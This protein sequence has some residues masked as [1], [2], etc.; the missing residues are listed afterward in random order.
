MKVKLLLAALLTCIASAAMA[1]PAPS[2]KSNRPDP[3]SF[4]VL[5]EP[6]LI[7]PMTEITR[8]YALHRNV[9]MLT[10]FDD[11]VEQEMKLLDGEQG[12]VLITSYPAV[13][14][15]LRQ[16]GL[17]DV[18]SQASVAADTLVLAATSKEGRRNRGDLL[19]ALTTQPLLLANSRR[20]IE[21]LYGHTI[22]RQLYDGESLL[23]EPKE[24][25]LRNMLY[26]AVSKNDGIGILL[27]SEAKKLE[28]VDLIIPL[29]DAK[30]PPVVYQAFAVAGENMPVAR[31]FIEFL[32]SSEAQRIFMRHGFSQP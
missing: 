21:G 19:T 17:I 26:D 16:R 4:T 7:L 22:A 15:D 27:Q 25:T 14:T 6:Q 11:S 20:Y 18:Y 9:N 5:A 3:V 30:H 13:I 10:A 32:R 24:Y 31:N 2:Q 12:D 8:I 28:G 23:L 1:T 29:N